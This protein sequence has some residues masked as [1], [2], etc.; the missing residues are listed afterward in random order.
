MG[1]AWTAGAHYIDLTVLPV[2]LV[3]LLLVT[4]V[5]V[6]VLY[7]IVQVNFSTCMRADPK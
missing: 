1:L 3:D 2:V 4:V 5:P 7:H 6:P